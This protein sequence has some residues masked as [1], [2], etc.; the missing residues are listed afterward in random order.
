MVRLYLWL[1]WGEFAGDDRVAEAGSLVRAITKGLVRGMTTATKRYGGAPGQAKRRSLWINDFEIALDA[2]RT[3]TVYRDLGCRHFFLLDEESM[4]A[5]AAHE[6]GETKGVA[7]ASSSLRIANRGLLILGDGG[8]HFIGPGK[9]A[10]L[11]VENFAETGFA[12]EVHGFGRAFA[13]ATM[14]DDFARRIQFVH[15]AR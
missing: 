5:S 4:P 13:A 1:G 12:Q 7:S 8:I 2:N 10:A 3:V 14:R 15:A 6:Q 11:Q 9:D